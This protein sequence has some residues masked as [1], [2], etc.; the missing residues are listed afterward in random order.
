M[1]ESGPESKP[2]PRPPRL[3]ILGGTRD[4]AA[5]AHGAHARFGPRVDMVSSLAGHTTPPELPGRMRIGGFGGAEG[6]AAHLRAEAV[7]ALIDATHP[8]AAQ[9]SANA[10]A[11]CRETGTPRLMLVRPAWSLEGGGPWIDAADARAAAAHIRAMQA[12]RVFLTTG[13]RGETA[14]FAGLKDTFFLLRAM[15]TPPAPETVPLQ[16]YKVITGRPPFSAGAEIKL[17]REHGIDAMVTKNSGGALNQGKMEA[18]RA[19]N[20]PTVIIRRPPSPPGET[21]GDVEAALMWIEKLG[22]Q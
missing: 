13:V 1:P 14:A 5:L 22:V 15:E 2:A 7:D 9:I 10:E 20:L 18:A 19:L 8:F 11:A 3:L 12:K 17:M 16:K 6:L 21:A 4:A